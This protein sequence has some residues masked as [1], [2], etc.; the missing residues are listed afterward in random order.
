MLR[1][2]D[3]LNGDAFLNR[4]AG[5]ETVNEDIGVQKERLRNFVNVHSVLYE[6]ILFLGERS[7]ADASA[8]RIARAHHLVR[9][10]VQAIRETPRSGYAVRWQLFAWQPRVTVLLLKERHFGSH[11]F[12][13]H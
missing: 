8:G 3:Q 11:Q 4:R 5:V 13:V 10:S 9:H 2:T 12:S 1:I 7:E 6:K